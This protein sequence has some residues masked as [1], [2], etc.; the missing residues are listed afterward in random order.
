[1][2]D[3]MIKIKDMI[4]EYARLVERH[5]A[6]EIDAGCCRTATDYQRLREREDARKE[7]EDKL[8]AF[9]DEVVK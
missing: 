9:I 3:N 5:K 7:Y 2:Y 8:D 6:A 4:R 1:M